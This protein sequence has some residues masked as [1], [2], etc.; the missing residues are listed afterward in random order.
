MNLSSLALDLL[1]S[2]LFQGVS[3]SDG[4]EIILESTA[5]GAQGEFYRLWKGAERGE[6]GFLP[7]FLPWFLTSE[8][9]KPVPKGFERTHAEDAYAELYDLS[10]EQIYWRRLKIAQGGE[11][12]FK[13]EY[14]ATAD[15][16]FLAEGSNVFDVEKLRSVVVK[17]P[18]GVEEYCPIRNSWGSNANGSLE[19]WEYPSFEGQYIIGVD[20]SGGV[21]QDYSTAVVMNPSRQVIGMYRNNRIDPGSFGDLLFYLGRW[22]N[23]GL[24][25]CE[26]NN[27]GVATLLQLEKMR[28]P[29]IYYQT[30]ILQIS[31]ES[32]TKPGFATTGSSKPAIIGNLK[33]AIVE[34][35]VGISSNV[36]IDELCNYIAK[37]NGRT[38]AAP[39]SHDDSVMA[40]A[41]ALEGL[42]THSDK[43]GANVN[44]KEFSKDLGN[45]NTQWL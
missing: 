7:I 29:N 36:M 23:N 41:I 10:D 32:S 3:E 35:D 33:R 38:E 27:H 30:K 9:S 4:T 42:R 24:I 21:G 31:N 2:G 39:G 22:Y 25:I 16:A 1:T 44:W 13:Q 40:L 18:K 43:L 45:E 14:P 8:Y 5:N 6:N 34:D 26:N 37:D 11:N 12:K 15:E 17:K 19:V 28:Y 20:V